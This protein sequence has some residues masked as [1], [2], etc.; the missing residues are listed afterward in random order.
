MSILRE[1]QE[2]RALEQINELSKKTLKSYVKKATTS[3][4]KH[5]EKASK[6][7]DKAMST[8]GEKYPEK[9]ERHMHA[10][11]KHIHKWRNRDA[12]LKTANNKLKEDVESLE[13]LSMTTLKSYASKAHVSRAKAAKREDD[14]TVG[15]R[16]AGLGMAIDKHKRDRAKPQYESLTDDD[17]DAILEEMTIEEFEQLDELSKKT[18]GSYVVKGSNDMSYHSANMQRAGRAMDT[19][20]NAKSDR[21]NK[22]DYDAAA[23]ELVSSDRKHR[24]RFKGIKRAVGQLTKEEVELDE[25]RGQ[26]GRAKHEREDDEWGSKD[27]QAK[28]NHRKNGKPLTKVIDE[29][30]KRSRG[31]PKKDRNLDGEIAP[32][33]GVNT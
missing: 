16:T 8:N 23:S 21:Y 27:K 24:N 18:L 22:S 30:L 15:K 6:E 7:E 32:N 14:D 20:N 10:A 19:H 9:Q 3:A 25:G 4:E 26:R 13:E 11:G 33:P 5:Y 2:R 1:I 31:R 17:L 28:P 29:A 12:G